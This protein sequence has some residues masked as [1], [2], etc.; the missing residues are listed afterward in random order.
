[1]TM[2]SDVFTCPALD[3]EE[4]AK[5]IRNGAYGYNYQYLGNARQDSG[6]HKRWD[7]FSVPMH[8]IKAPAGTVLIADSRGAWKPH[9]IH[10]YT[11]DPPRLGVEQN[12]TRFGPDREHVPVGASE[13]EKDLFTFSPVEMRHRG[14]G[15]VAFVDTHVEALTLKQLGYELLG[16]DENEKKKK[17][18]AVPVL[19][20]TVNTVTATNRLW[21]GLGQDR[22]AD[23]RER[24]NP[25]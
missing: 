4:Y 20:P 17:N 16:I 24:A 1:M 22:F 9:G 23:E 21:T 3:D 5:N 11:L 13:E 19:D 18:T 25:P 7:N 2:T 15:N 8:R 14:L 10:S 6:D 12:A